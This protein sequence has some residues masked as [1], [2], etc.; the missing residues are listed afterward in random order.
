MRRLP[1]VLLVVL[2]AACSAPADDDTAAAPDTLTR[3]QR[4]SVIGASSL[5]GARSVQ[6]A[7]DTR[8]SASARNAAIDSLMKD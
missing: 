6:R 8:D 4:D 2:S 3:A 1:L 5:P 7:I